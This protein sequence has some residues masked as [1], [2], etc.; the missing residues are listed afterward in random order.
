MGQNDEA[1]IASAT[2]KLDFYSN[3][4]SKPVCGGAERLKYRPYTVRD[5]ENPPLSEYHGCL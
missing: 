5:F 2:A 3:S 4:R 1:A